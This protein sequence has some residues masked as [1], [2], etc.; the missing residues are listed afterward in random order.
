MPRTRSIAWSEVKLGVVGLVAL[1]LFTAMV[2]AVGGQG[3]YPWQ[4]YA[5]KTRFVDVNGLKTGAVVRLNGKEV[6]KVTGVEFA[7]P[8]IDVAFE[9]S[10]SVR[11]LV[12]TDST[13]SIGSL[14]LLGEPIIVLTA[15]S[16]GAPLQDWAYVK[17]V[18]HAGFNDLTETASRGLEEAGSLVADLRAG[19]GSLGK[20]VTDDALYNELRDFA[21]S[22]ATVAAALKDGKGTLGQLTRDSAAYDELKASLERLHAI[23]DRIDHGQGPLARLLND[24]AMA[25]SLAGTTSNIEQIS[26]RLN[27]GEGTAGKLMTDQQLYDRFNALTNRIDQLVSG[28]ESGQGTAGRVLKDPQLYENMNQTVS[29]M[30]QL[31]EAIRKDPKKYLNVKVSIF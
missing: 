12:T 16:T 15:A 6:G 1:A 21:S 9:I 26:G 28:L 5:L 20:L 22:A 10:N 2:L 3:G 29:E 30:R 7:G 23:T 13:A 4:R 24:E 27:R 8:Q 25:R 14:S 17:S 18:Q 19:R 31:I 11:P